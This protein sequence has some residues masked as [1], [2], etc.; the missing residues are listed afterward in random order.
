MLM[1][2]A[3]I[4]LEGLQKPKNT[5]PL[6]TFEDAQSVDACVDMSDNDIGGFSEAAISHVPASQTNPA[7]AFFRGRISNE[8]PPR[9]PRVERTGY[10]AWRTKDRP[11]TVFGR[12]LWDVDMYKFL[13]MRVK[14]D[15]RKYKVNIQTE[16]IE[17]TD[18][19]QHRL[20][21]RNPGQW[22]TILIKWSDFVRTNH[23]IVVEPQSEMLKERVRTIGVGLTDRQPGPFEFRIS[24]IWATNGLTQ[25][26]YEESGLP[27]MEIIPKDTR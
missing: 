3:A 8:L 17:Y 10:A 16:S 21:T 22:E 18:L 1:P 2:W 4:K 5:L 7:H 11:P 20:Y 12:S 15:G 6:W 23:G 27:D 19:H 9:D 25:T 26:E 14:S 13:A 24:K